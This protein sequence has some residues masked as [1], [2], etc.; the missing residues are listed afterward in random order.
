MRPTLAA[1]AIIAATLYGL[2]RVHLRVDPPDPCD[3]TPDPWEC[4]D[5][6]SDLI[7]WEN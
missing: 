2:W 6:G 1:A 7:G 5:T 4:R 3:R